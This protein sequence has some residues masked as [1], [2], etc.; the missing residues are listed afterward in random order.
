MVAFLAADESR[1]CSAQTYAVD[2]G[3]M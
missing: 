2:A 3:W 1:M